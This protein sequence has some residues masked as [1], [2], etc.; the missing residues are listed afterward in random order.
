M[1]VLLDAHLAH[2]RSIWTYEFVIPGMDGLFDVYGAE[3]NNLLFIT[4][5]VRYYFHAGFSLLPQN[6]LHL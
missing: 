2:V 1:E 4:F 3:M 5:M 6:G